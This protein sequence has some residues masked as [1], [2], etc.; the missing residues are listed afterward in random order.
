MTEDSILFQQTIYEVQLHQG[1]TLIKNLP[2]T[3]KLVNAN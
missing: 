2:R 3:T 1:C